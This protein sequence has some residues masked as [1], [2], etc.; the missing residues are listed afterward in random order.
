MNSME[1]GQKAHSESQT[2]ELNEFNG[3][4]AEGTLG[5]PDD[6]TGQK[7]HSESQTMELNEFNGSWAE[8]T[9]G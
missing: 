5:E 7:T 2:M 9:L 4:W 1:A 8:G 6:G 3:S